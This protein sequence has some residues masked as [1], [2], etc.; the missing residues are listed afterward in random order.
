MKSKKKRFWVAEILAFMIILAIHF[1]IIVF[2]A[3]F[4]WFFINLIMSL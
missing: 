4:L 2:W 1:F 3:I